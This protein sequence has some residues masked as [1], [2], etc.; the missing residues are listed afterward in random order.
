MQCA[1]QTQE[2]SNNDMTIDLTLVK[3]CQNLKNL[4]KIY[5]SRILKIAKYPKQAHFQL[6]LQ[7]VLCLRTTVLV[8]VQKIRQS[9]LA[10]TN[11]YKTHHQSRIEC[12]HNS[13]KL[14]KGKSM[15][16]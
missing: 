12:K 11:T 10:K 3:I 5:E 9:F 7:C 15:N 4:E 8:K 2:R 1:C 6:F 13:D 16:K 14:N